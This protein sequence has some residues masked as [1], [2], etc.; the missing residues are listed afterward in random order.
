MAMPWVRLHALKDYLDMPL[1]AAA[2]PGVKV[3]FNLVPSL[4]DQIDIYLAGGTDRHLELSRMA[5][6]E[7]SADLKLELLGSFFSA[8]PTQMI[9]PYRRYKQLYAKYRGGADSPQTLVGLFS[10]QELRDLQ[11]WSNLVWIDPMFRKEPL[12][13]A[14]FEKERN[15]TEEDK[16]VLLDWQ[17]TLLARIVP[18]YRDLQEQERIE[19]SFTPYYHPILPLLCDTESAKEALPSLPM[20]RARFAHPEDA[21]TQIH[22]SVEKYREIFGRDMRG[23][24]PSEGSISED[25]LRLIIRHGITWS[26]S[27]QEV[28]EQSLDKS[29]MSRHGCPIHRVY[30]FGPGLKLFFRDHALSDRIGFVYSTWEPKRAVADF[31]G[32]LKQLRQ[33]YKDQLDQV[34]IPIVLDGENAWEYFPD[35][36]SEFLGL[37]YEALAEA[38]DVDTVTMSEACRTLPAVTLPRIFAGSWINHNFRIWIGHREDNTAWDLLSRTRRDLVTFQHDHPEYDRA[39]LDSAWQQIYVAEGSDWCW[40]YGDEHR[41]PSNEDFD[42]IFRQHLIAVYELLGLDIP[43]D[44]LRPIFESAE[45]VAITYP[46]GLITPTIDGRLTHFYEWSG[47]GQFDCAKSGGSMHKVERHLQAVFFAYDRERVYIRL[48]FRFV[49]EIDLLPELK[50]VLKCLVPDKPA[51]EITVSRGQSEEPGF[52]RCVFGN[53]AEVAVARD[54]LWPAGFGRLGLRVLLLEG[55][56]KLEEW[57]EHQPLEFEVPESRQE[58]FWP[59]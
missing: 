26:A 37:F 15:F 32:H 47:S 7:L 10:S 5:A 18:T 3:T 13:K 16:I 1:T 58:M 33:I 9:N 11:V 54:A 57:P 40:W 39:R 20:P 4:L 31:M 49:D 27:D 12:V 55:G 28:L 51:R 34:V 36:A 46:D 2:Q 25:A 29:G 44:H 45:T 24:W 52:Y 6:G 41:G 17:L 42:R 14:L 38:P 56:R 35:D 21:E 19:V 48:D 53:V 30:E 22:L 23:M 8:N 50:T 43:F 59:L